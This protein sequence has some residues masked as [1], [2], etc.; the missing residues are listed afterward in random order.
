VDNE[1]S[2]QKVAVVVTA[3]GGYVGE[4][5]LEDLL[6]SERDRALREHFGSGYRNELRRLA[7]LG[8][9]GPEDDES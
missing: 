7:E 2:T 3:I 4:L 6:P 9:D 5:K 1:Q 8:V